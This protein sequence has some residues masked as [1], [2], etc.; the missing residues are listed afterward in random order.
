MKWDD[1]T[2]YTVSLDSGKL[3]IDKC[4]EIIANLYLLFPFQNTVV[5][6]CE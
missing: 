5:F 2:H 3:G 1:A 6:Y 4:V